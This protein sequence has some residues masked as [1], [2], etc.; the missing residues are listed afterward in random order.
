M[1]IVLV[2]RL[3]AQLRI[4]WA[5]EFKLSS[6]QCRENGLFFK[7]DGGK[8]GGRGFG[9]KTRKKL[10]KSNGINKKKRSIFVPLLYLLVLIL[11]LA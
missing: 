9:I 6:V 3:C 5:R 2:G 7:L 1:K 11:I 8:S 10:A 4:L